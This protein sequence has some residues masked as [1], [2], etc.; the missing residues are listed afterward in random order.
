M[1]GCLTFLFLPVLCFAAGPA[2]IDGKVTDASGKP[3][4]H[5]TVMVYE[6]GVRTGYSTFCP[7]CWV[8]CGKHTLTDAEGNFSIA[9]LNPDLIF[10]LLVAKNGYAATS[11]KKVDPAKGPAETAALKTRTSPQNPAQYV[12]G[13]VVDRHGEPVPDAVV[14]QQGVMMPDGGAR[15]GAIGWIDLI[16]VTNANGEFELA[17]SQPAEKIILNVSPR[18]MSSKLF[19]EP[20]GADRKTLVVTEGATVKGRLVRDGKPVANAQV[21]LSTHS[22]FSGTMFP[23]M[24]IGTQE[25]G[26]FS[27][28]NVPPGRIFYL[29]GKMESLAPQGLAADLVECE[30]KDDGQVVNVG[31]IQVKPAHTLRGTVVL[32][33]GK[34]IPPG[35]HISL[36]ADR[37]WDSQ[38]AVL[39]AE[40]HFEFRGLSSGVYMLMPSVRNYK[41]AN[42]FGV[43]VLVN[44][45]IENLV[46][47]LQPSNG[48]R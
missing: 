10:N 5:A 25:D 43:E 20:T 30:T 38:S 46:L 47:T 19:T 7:T 9:G 21:G 26:T 23:E 36:S 11:V 33:D 4:E 8:D 34:P 48:N 35:M 3:L 22:Q 42:N 18:G 17:H 28:T 2:N 39:D 13:R 16:A 40:G 27:I 15:F 12:R 29:Y 45:D 31:D 14:E 44:R 24:R 32:S 1:R 6:A 37:A 41:G